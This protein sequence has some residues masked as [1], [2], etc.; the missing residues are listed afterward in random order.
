ML[1][2]SRRHDEDV[3]DPAVRRGTA[4]RVDARERLR[5]GLR[6]QANPAAFWLVVGGFVAIGA[7]LGLLMNFG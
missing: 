2:G 6:P 5:Q 4:P 1:F 3:S 7:G